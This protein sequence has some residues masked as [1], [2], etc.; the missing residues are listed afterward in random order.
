VIA[1]RRRAGRVS[2]SFDG[3]APG[4]RCVIV[5]TATGAGPGVGVI[6]V[7]A[8]RV[9]LVPGG[10]V[11]PVNVMDIYRGTSG[12]LTVTKTITG[13]AARRHGRIAILVACGAPLRVFA[14]LIPP[15]VLVGSVSRRFDGLPARTRCVVREI[16]PG[17]ARGVAV[18]ASRPR[19]V[20]VRVRANGSVRAHLTDRF[21]LAPAAQFTG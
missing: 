10:R 6:A 18:R 12:S 3:I 13:P 8:G 2:R 11:R 15:R 20:V 14:F 9:V 21:V 19:G 17:R 16:V 1:A 4:S 5:E 7:G